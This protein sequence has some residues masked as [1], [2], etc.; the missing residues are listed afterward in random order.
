MTKK[1]YIEIS[2]AISSQY[3]A[4]REPSETVIFRE[5][6]TDVAYSLIL[7]FESDN[8]RFD[9]AKFLTACGIVGA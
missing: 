8:P 7:V 6:I 3:H 4:P 1:D 2:D 9:R 5:A